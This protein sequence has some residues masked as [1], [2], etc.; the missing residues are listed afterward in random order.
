[1]YTSGPMAGSGLECGLG[2]VKGYLTAIKVKGHYFDGWPVSK[3]H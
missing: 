2:A 3:E 1:M